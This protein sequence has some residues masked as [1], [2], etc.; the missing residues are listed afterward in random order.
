[1]SIALSIGNN[2]TSSA[3]FKAAAVNNTSVNNITTFSSLPAVGNLKLL[4]TQTAS[5]SA[6]L[7]F[8]S[9]IDS[10][11][12][13]YYITFSNM[14]PSTADD[15]FR[16]YAS[17]NGGSSY[18][19]AQTQTHFRAYLTESD[20]TSAFVYYTGGDNTPGSTSGIILTTEVSNDNDAGASGWV[21]I[22]NPSST[23]HVKHFF[24][25]N[26]NQYYTPDPYVMNGY[27]GGFW[28]TT[29]AI[30]AIQFKF[31]SGNIDSGTIKL[32][33]IL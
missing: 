3:T 12:D 6:S 8:T 27:V 14:H 29:S 18:S 5:S 31:N 11:Y 17:T 15:W 28:D 16:M 21:K 2:L 7:D 30:N 23:T 26:V 32:Y 20:T 33:G 13:V 19:V 24:S 9:G 1:M 22:Y 25:S 4:S 10:T